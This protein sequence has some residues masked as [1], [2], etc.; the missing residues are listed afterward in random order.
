MILQLKDE[1]L[2]AGLEADTRSGQEKIQPTDDAD[3]KRRS[4]GGRRSWTSRRQTANS[5]CRQ[6]CSGA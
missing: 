6:Y 1:R 5:E 2:G 3:P 4:Q